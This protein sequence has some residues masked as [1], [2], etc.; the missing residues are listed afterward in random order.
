MCSK[1]NPDMVKYIFLTQEQYDSI[2]DNKE[3]NEDEGKDGEST[4]E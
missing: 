3:T 2:Y 4:N 1:D